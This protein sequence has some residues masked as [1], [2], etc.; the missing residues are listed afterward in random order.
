MSA[1]L[2][3]VFSGFCHGCCLSRGICDH[4]PV[5]TRI[6]FVVRCNNV[7]HQHFC[8]SRFELLTIHDCG[9]AAMCSTIYVYTNAKLYPLDHDS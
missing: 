3:G 4:F 8:K 1:S 5:A 7:V 6:L 9:I 2:V